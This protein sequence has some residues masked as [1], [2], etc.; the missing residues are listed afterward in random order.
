MIHYGAELCPPPP[1]LAVS[2]AINT[3]SERITSRF[4]LDKITHIISE[5]WEIPERQLIENHPRKEEI[6]TVTVSSNERLSG[7]K[8]DIYM[9]AARLADMAHP[10]SPPILARVSSGR[11]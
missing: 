9:L 6:Y 1:P 7:T 8:V 5:T 3:D 2:S 10:K 4:D 11:I